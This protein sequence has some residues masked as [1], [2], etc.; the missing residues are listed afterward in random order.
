MHQL[1]IFS[2]NFKLYYSHSTNIQRDIDKIGNRFRSSA[3]VLL[4][5]YTTFTFKTP[6]VTPQLIVK[7]CLFNEVSIKPN[8]ML[9]YKNF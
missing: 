9:F 5:I 6:M 4:I 3:F 7:Y 2:Y 8:T 1:F